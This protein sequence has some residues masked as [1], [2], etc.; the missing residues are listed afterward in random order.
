MTVFAVVTI[1]ALAVVPGNYGLRVLSIFI[2]AL[3]PVGSSTQRK[4]LLWTSIIVSLRNP[5][6]IGMNNFIL[7]NPRALVTHNSYTQ[8]SAEMGVLA[9]YCYLMF[10]FEPIRR[11]FWIER[12]LEEKNNH[13]WIYYLSLGLQASFAGFC[14]GSFFDSAAYQWFLYYLAAYAVCLRRIYQLQVEKA[15]V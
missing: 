2:P 4:D 13:N 10:I 11:L 15:T 7:T 8:V 3:D 14:V 12:E 9:L 6:G 5:W 1:I